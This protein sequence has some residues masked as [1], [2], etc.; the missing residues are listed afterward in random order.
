MQH[1]VFYDDTCGLCQRSI[2]FFIKRDKKRELLFAP[3][4][5]KTAAKELEEWLKDHSQVDS[6]ILVEK[7]NAKTKK[8]LYYSKAVLRLLWHIGGIWSLF[9]LFSF[10]PS[11][12]LW[13]A[14]CIY[15]Q[16]AKRRRDL[17]LLPQEV[18]LQKQ[19]EKQFLP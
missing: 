14:D 16:I 5:G 15:R 8:T 18:D 12:L 7:E 1:I 17:C 9:G 6:I 2:I 11:W 10:L 19:H 3:L 4:N 13:P